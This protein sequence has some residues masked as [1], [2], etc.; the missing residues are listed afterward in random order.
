MTI[1]SRKEGKT[2]VQKLITLWIKDRQSVFHVAL[3]TEVQ[4][5]RF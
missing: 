5:L 1:Y 3:T 2:I 4:D